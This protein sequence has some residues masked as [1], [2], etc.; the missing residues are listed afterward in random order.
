M[1]KTGNVALNGATAVTDAATAVT[2]AGRGLP[3]VR[4][5]GAAPVGVGCASARTPGTPFEGVAR[6]SSPGTRL[7]A[8]PA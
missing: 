2:A 6:D 1:S 7:T 3:T 8:E 5:S 4:A